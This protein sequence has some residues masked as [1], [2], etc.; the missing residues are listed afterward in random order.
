[1]THN[2]KTKYSHAINKNKTKKVDDLKMRNTKTKFLNFLRNPM[3]MKVAA[4][5]FALLFLATSHT[6]AA[7]DAGMDKFDTIIDVV[8]KWLGRIGLVVAFFGAGQLALGFKQDD[9]DGKVRGM[10]TLAAGFMLF[11]ITESLSLFG[12]K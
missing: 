10:K 12:L 6:Y 1:M 8:A 5:S 3:V 9:A 7:A 4:F 11:G 2:P